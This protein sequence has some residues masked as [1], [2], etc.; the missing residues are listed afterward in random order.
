MA[1]PIG[2]AGPDSPI[3]WLEAGDVLGLQALRARPNLELNCLA[4]V[5]ALVAV[6]LDCG[7]MDEDILTGLALD[8]PVPLAGVEPL[9][10][11]LLFHVRSPFFH[12][13]AI[14]CLSYRGGP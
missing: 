2:F 11:S 3:A 4:F 12:H 14:W 6:H 5:E 8:E 9:H 10:C 7:K 13:E 1:S